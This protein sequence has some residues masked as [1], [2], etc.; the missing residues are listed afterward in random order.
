MRFSCILIIL[1]VVFS[2]TFYNDPILIHKNS[3]TVALGNIGEFNE[4]A[5]AIFDNPSYLSTQENNITITHYRFMSDFTYSNLAA[6]Y[7]PFGFGLVM[8][9]ASDYNTAVDAYGEFIPAGSYSYN[10]AV[11]LLSHS[12]Q[13][14]NL[15][16][17]V[18]GKLYTSNLDNISASGFNIDASTTILLKELTISAII[19]NLFNNGKNSIKWNNGDNTEDLHSTLALA[20]MYNLNPVKLY[21]KTTAFL[22]API[23]P[24]INLGA[25][26]SIESLVDLMLGYT[27]YY[28]DNKKQSAMSYGVAIN[29]GNLGVTYSA[30]PVK[31][32]DGYYEGIQQLSFRVKI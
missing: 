12:S 21:A 30:N 22:N 8:I 23:D 15:C 4:D 11:Y 5:S 3:K 28:S 6:N 24:L 1:S 20:G 10:N 2:A 31:T 26:Y 16:F 29:L 18:T 19:T 14:N 17:G 27:Q 25:S 13:R 7:G 32:V 9:G